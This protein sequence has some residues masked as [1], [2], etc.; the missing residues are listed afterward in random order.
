MTQTETGKPARKPI[1]FSGIQ[2][3]GV[4]TLGNYLGAVKNWV[5]LQDDYRCIYSIVNLHAITV[6]QDPAALRAATLDVFAL[7]LACGIDPEKSLLFMQSH[8]KT[9][10]EL[11]W[12]LSCYTQFGE[13]SRMTQFKDKS[14]RY[15]DNINAGLFTYPV[16]MAADILLYQT[17]LVPVGADQKQHLEISRDIAGRF[18]GIHGNVFSIPEPYIP[19]EGARV[20]SLQEPTKKMSKSDPNPKAY[21][22]V[23][24]GKDTIIKKFKGA[25]TDSEA[26]VAYGEGKEGINNLMSIYS[27][28]TGRSYEQI[29]AD[30]AGKGYGD[31]KV[32]VG[33][34]VAEH[35][36]PIQA[37]FARIRQDKA[38]LESIYRAGAQQ[39]L[40]ISQRTLDKVYKK[41]GFLPLD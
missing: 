6:R 40:A 11:A 12:V 25:V 18:N 28:V 29:E 16:L 19:K 21:V 31:F 26:R 13:L 3:T 32:A 14:A 37:E 1:I 24:D 9:H 30:F 34:T 15:Q 20:M 23:L 17:N 5:A 22:A 41:V 10:A 7:L 33:E 4:I 35:L 8:V 38:Y 36:R 27:A 2:P 39:A